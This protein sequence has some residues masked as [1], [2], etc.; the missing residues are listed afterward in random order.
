[1]W[2]RS[3]RAK[4][5]SASCV[6]CR[7]TPF[8]DGSRP[9]AAAAMAAAAPAGA[10]AAVSPGGYLNLKDFS[11]AHRGVDTSVAALYPGTSRWINRRHG[12]RYY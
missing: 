2:V 5:G 9:G 10:Q 12:G 8:V 3:R 1:M 11:E 4:A 6:Y 7:A